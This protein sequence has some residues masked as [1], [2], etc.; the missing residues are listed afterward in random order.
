[1]QL[2]QLVRYRM[3]MDSGFLTASAFFCG[4]SIF[5]TALYYFVLSDVSKIP[6]GAMVLHVILPMVWCVAYAV[7]LKGIRLNIPL[8]YGGM[9]ALYCI[10]MIIWGFQNPTVLGSVLGLVVF[11]LCALAFVAT[12][13]GLVPGKYYLAT[14]LGAV[15][16]MQIFW[17]DLTAYIMPLKIKEYLPVLARTSGVATLSLMCFGMQGRPVRRGK[18]V[19]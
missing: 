1:M 12:T 4:L 19:K 14:V 8:V 5:C 18:E 7:L 9:G 11:L 10:F 6:G 17:K 3:K 2:K 16:L 13:M 15:V